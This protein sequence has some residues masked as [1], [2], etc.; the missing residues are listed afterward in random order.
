MIRLPRPKLISQARALKSVIEQL[1]DISLLAVDTES[2]SMFVYQEQ[3]CLI[4]LSARQE[5]QILDFI[6]D[7]LAIPDVSV[8]GELFANPAI[9]KVFHAA[10]YDIT[11]MKRDFGFEFVNI[12]DTYFAAQTLG[13]TR[14]GLSSLLEEHFSVA[15]DKR[16]QQAEWHHRPLSLEELQYAQM[17]THFLPALR[18]IQLNE[19]QRSGYLEEA[20]E[21]FRELASLPATDRSFDPEGFWRLKG[22]YLLTGSS[23]AILRQLYLWREKTAQKRDIPSNKVMPDSTLVDIAT[24]CP[25]SA[26][27]LQRIPGITRQTVKRDG[28]AI[29]ETVA[30]GKNEIPPRRHP[31]SRTSPEVIARYEALHTWRKEKA[32]SRGV[33]SNV[34]LSKNALWVL[35]LRH[36]KTDEELAVIQEIGPHRR[37]KYGNELLNL[38]KGV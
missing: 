31:Q 22:A 8:L 37:A 15:L 5:E 23:L 30:R 36:P 38:L 21:G 18:D 11:C 34:I 26:S 16:F 6:I 28:K 3:V 33:E 19:L 17:D 14:V 24:T 10:D 27:A 32:L 25:L 20:Q 9:E 35:A 2:N 12:F 7:P 4:Q 1:Q 29:L 13:W